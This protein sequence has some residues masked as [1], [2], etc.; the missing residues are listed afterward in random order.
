MQRMMQLLCVCAMQ[1]ILST[2]APT[3]VSRLSIPDIDLFKLYREWF[4][5]YFACVLP[6]NVRATSV[7]AMSMRGCRDALTVDAVVVTRGRTPSRS[8]TVTSTR[9]PRSSCGSAWL[10]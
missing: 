5:T 6:Y 1:D 3:V 7:V 2:K 8:S 4:R 10:Y 9:A